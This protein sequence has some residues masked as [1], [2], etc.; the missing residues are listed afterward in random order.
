MGS[1]KSGA[2]KTRQQRLASVN[3]QLLDK[4]NHVEAEAGRYEKALVQYARESNWCAISKSTDGQETTSTASEWL[5]PGNG[6][7]LAQVCLKRKEEKNESS[8]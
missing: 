7:Y 1:I 6:P 4:L 3:Q 8:S 2:K 5:G